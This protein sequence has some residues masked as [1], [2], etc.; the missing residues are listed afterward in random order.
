[1]RSGSGDKQPS[2]LEREGSTGHGRTAARA[3]GHGG[4]AGPRAGKHGA[5]RGLASDRL[6]NF[7]RE[8]APVSCPARKSE[9]ALRTFSEASV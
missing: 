7:G 4:E 1:M 6:G 5:H 3:T 2:T 8:S 9:T